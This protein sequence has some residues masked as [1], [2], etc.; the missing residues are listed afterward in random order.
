LDLVVPDGI[1]PALKGGARPIIEGIEGF[2]RAP[3]DGSLREFFAKKPN[4]GTTPEDEAQ[5]FTDEVSLHSQSARANAIALKQI[6]QRFSP[7]DLSEMTADEHREWRHMLQ[8]HANAV[9]K[10]T[11][12]MR[13]NLEPIF[14]SSVEDKQAHFSNLKDDADLVDAA[15][16]LSDLAASNDS[17]VWHSFAAST[18]AS[19]VTLVCLPEFWESLLDAEILAQEISA[20]TTDGN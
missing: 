10:E 11:R 20:N 15:A 12:S 1:R 7:E 6:A 9:L 19:N 8:A 2:E 3:A 5:R 14:R 17:A 4:S 13:E 16:R 18:Q